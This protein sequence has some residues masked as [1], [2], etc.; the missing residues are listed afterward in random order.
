MKHTQR[1]NELVEILGLLP[2][3]EGGFYKETYRSVETID[4]EQALMTSIY[5]LLTSDHPSHFHRIQSDEHW[6]F[7]EGSPLI[8]HVIGENGHEQKR[9]G[10]DLSAG[11]SPYHLVKKQ[12]IFGSEVQ[13]ESGYAL[14]SCAVAPGFMFS[15]FEL[16][17]RQDLLNQYPQHDEIIRRLT[18]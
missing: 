5:F 8:V 9:L 14:V 3:P 17:S 16:F 4:G 11:Q 1:I 7:H 6:Y 15:D 18:V 10:L 13:E 2:H 12:E